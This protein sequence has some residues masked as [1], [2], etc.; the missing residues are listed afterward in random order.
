[1]AGSCLLPSSPKSITVPQLLENFRRA[2]FE[3]RVLRA[4]RNQEASLPR[5]IAY[6]CRQWEKDQLCHG[7]DIAVT[8]FVVDHKARE[9]S[10]QEA[11]MVSR[12]LTELGIKTQIL[13]LLW[14]QG[15]QTPSQVSAFET[16]ARRL[17]FQALGRACRDHR[18][19]AL[20]MGHHRDDNVETTLWRLSSGARG[21]GLAGIPPVA[22]I[23]ECHGIYGVSESGSAVVL[24]PRQDVSSTGWCSTPEQTSRATDDSH[25]TTTPH[26]KIYM[27]TGG[28]LICR[29]LLSFPKANLL[30]TCHENQVPYVSDPTNFDATLTARNAIRSL[31][32]SNRLPRALQPPSILSLV[33]NS[34]VLLQETTDLSNQ[35]LQQCKILDI[36]LTTC[37]LILKFP[38]PLSTPTSTSSSTNPQSHSTARHHKTHQ[39]QTLTLRRITE[40]ISPFPENHFPLRSF[41]HFTSRVFPAPSTRNPITTISTRQTFTLG[42][43]M[44]QPL[45]RNPTQLTQGD[46]TIAD[47]YQSHHHNNENDS[48]NNHNQ[49]YNYNG[50]GNIWLLSRQ[51]FIRNRLPTLHFD[52]HVH[53]PK[54]HPT[55]AT[56]PSQSEIQTQC[57][58]TDPKYT[59]WRLWDERYWF[60]FSVILGSTDSL[61]DYPGYE[62]IIDTIS[63]MEKIPLVVR[64]FQKSDLAFIRQIA[65]ERPRYRSRHGNMSRRANK[66]PELDL[67]TQRLSREAPGQTRFTLPLVSITEGFRD[68]DRDLP[69]ALPTMNMWLPG[70]HDFLRTLGPWRIQWEWMYK[71]VDTEPLKLMGGLEAP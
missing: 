64:G 46:S 39:I 51:P 27:S 17:R 8:A 44:F 22:R 25:K 59:P 57:P 30:A 67:L 33:R 16:H 60:R 40:L 14:P 55:L 2:W 52:V 41:E 54:Q 56:S 10:A 21:A 3:F 24:Q 42:G 35:L 50:H 45:D 9:E 32:S 28:I 38:H 69:L 71:M 12:W 26:P 23:P 47:G 1:M 18:I 63:G 61:Q 49:N 13:E 62:N 36:N 70:M 31:L 20:L 15:A 65:N 58:S 5:R 7:H 43:V 19:E 4:K 37:T 11:A 48:D 66:D 53:V 6:L 68:L 29:P 34:Q